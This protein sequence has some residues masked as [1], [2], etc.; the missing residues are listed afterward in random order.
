MTTL[1][2]RATTGCIAHVVDAGPAAA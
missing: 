1:V 2:T